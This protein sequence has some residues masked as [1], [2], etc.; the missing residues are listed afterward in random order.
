MC[1]FVAGSKNAEKG[2]LYAN[3]FGIS[4]RNTLEAKQCHQVE[5]S[6]T[7]TIYSLIDRLTL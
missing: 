5:Q 4:L 7:R 2:R 1:R 3:D 6:P